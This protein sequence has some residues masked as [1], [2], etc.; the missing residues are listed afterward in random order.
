MFQIRF[1]M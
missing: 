1:L